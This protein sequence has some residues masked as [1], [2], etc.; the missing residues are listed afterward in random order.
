MLS[1]V[2]NNVET[3]SQHLPPKKNSFFVNINYPTIITS[4]DYR[5]DDVF[6]GNLHENGTGC[7]KSTGKCLLQDRALCP[8]CQPLCNARIV[9]YRCET[10]GN[11]RSYFI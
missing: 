11:R 5:W 7:Q 8:V 9:T 2:L 10:F 4:H 6:H 3:E 1:N